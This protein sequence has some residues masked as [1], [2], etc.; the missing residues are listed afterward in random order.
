MAFKIWGATASQL[1]YHILCAT[2]EKRMRGWEEREE[3]IGCKD[4][5]RTGENEKDSS[6]SVKPPHPIV[7]NSKGNFYPYFLLRL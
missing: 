2:K 1:K 7:V 4:G 3:L 6:A 5:N